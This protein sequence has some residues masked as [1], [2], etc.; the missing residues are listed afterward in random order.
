VAGEIADEKDRAAFLRKFVSG[1]DTSRPT[2]VPVQSAPDLSVSQKF[3]AE[4]L[5]KAETALAQHI[6]AIARVVVKRAAAK[7]RDEAEL[8]LLISDE[9]RDPAERKNFVRK[10]V[11]ASR[12]R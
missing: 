11:S 9:I 5:K 12:L 2:S 3:S 4:M 8:Y 10:A 7:A 6:G 1:E